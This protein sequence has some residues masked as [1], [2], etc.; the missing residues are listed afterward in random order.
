MKLPFLFLISLIL[1]TSCTDNRKECRLAGT[2]EFILP[3]T[4]SPAQE[5]YNIGDT[6]TFTSSFSDMVYD[7]HTDQIYHLENFKFDPHLIIREISDTVTNEAALEDFEVL[8]NEQTN[9][10]PF[11][12]DSGSISFVGE[13]AYENNQYT[14]TYQFIPQTTG[15]FLFNHGSTLLNDRQHFEGRCSNNVNNA[16]VTLNDGGENNIHLLHESPNTHYNEWIL[17][18]PDKRFHKFGGFAFRVKP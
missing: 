8:V 12:Y 18:K 11:Y 5:I 4:L 10:H 9:F 3:A 7:E 1:L 14:L 15:F 6:I 2:Y 17:E 16:T 13:Y